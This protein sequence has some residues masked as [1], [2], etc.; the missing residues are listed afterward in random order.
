[1]GIDANVAAEMPTTRLNR[2]TLLQIAGQAGSSAVA[3]G[4]ASQS[5]AAAS[6]NALPSA[7]TA[8]MQKPRYAQSTWS[9]LVA[10]V[11]TGEILYELHPDQMALTGSVRKLFSVGLALPA[12]AM[13][14]AGRGRH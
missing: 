7:I 13:V 11:A 6:N 10:D 12:A 3:F 1:M 2:R 8:V 9:L 14:A 5:R 4:L